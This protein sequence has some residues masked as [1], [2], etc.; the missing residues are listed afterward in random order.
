MAA[1]ADKVQYDITTL[2][3]A[4]AAT[5]LTSNRPLFEVRSHKGLF[6]SEW[7]P[8]ITSQLR[9]TLYF[10]GKAA[11][12]ISA[13]RVHSERSEWT[14]SERHIHKLGDA[15]RFKR[16]KQNVERV[17]RIPGNFISFLRRKAS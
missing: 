8:S 9:Q 5:H 16:R 11:S 13:S 3:N 6:Y 14:R 17:C 12:A 4:S 1:A 2:L 7:R 15:S 10:Q